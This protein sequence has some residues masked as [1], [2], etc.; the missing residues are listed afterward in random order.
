MDSCMLSKKENIDVLVDLFFLNPYCTS[1][2]IV[3]LGKREMNLLHITFLRFLRKHIKL[4]YNFTCHI[5]LVFYEVLLTFVVLNL[6][7]KI[8]NSIKA[9]QT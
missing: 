6:S 1:V 4:A 2:N 9:L 8:L 7:R 5:Y 3:L